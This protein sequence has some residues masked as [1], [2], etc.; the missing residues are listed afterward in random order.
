MDLESEEQH[1]PGLSVENKAESLKKSKIS[2]AR[3]FLLSI[4]QLEI[5]KKLPAG[6]DASILRWDTRSSGSNDK[7]GDSQSDWDSFTQDSGRRYGNQSRRPW[8]NPEHDGLLGSGA[9]PRPSGYAGAPL[10][11]KVRGDDNYVLNRSSEPYHPPRT[12]KALP[13]SRRD[14]TDSFNDETFGSTECSS[15]DRAEEERKRRASFELMR[16]EQQKALQEKLKQVDKRKELVTTDIDSLLE[17]PDHRQSVWSRAGEK[18][19]DHVT[20]VPQSDLGKHAMPAPAPAPRPLVPPGFATAALE[21]NVG[22]KLLVPTSASEVGNALLEDFTQANQTKGPLVGDGPGSDQENGKLS[23]VSDPSQ[24]QQNEI[25]TIGGPFAGGNDEDM[26]PASCFEFSNSSFGFENPTYRTSSVQ[27]ARESWVDGTITDFDAGRV[28]CSSAGVVDQDHAKTIL[29]K[30]FGNALA[31]NSVGSPSFVEIRFSYLIADLHTDVPVPDKWEADVQWQLIFGFKKCATTELFLQQ[32]QDELTALVASHAEKKIN[33]DTSSS[34]AKDLLSLI[35]SNEKG[36][37]MVSTMSN[38]RGIEHVQTISP[39]END[40]VPQKLVSSPTSS[41]MGIAEPPFCQVKPDVS[42]KVLTCEDLEQSILAEVNESS[43]H[44]QP[45]QGPWSISDAK[46]EQKMANVDDLASQHLLSLLHKGSN[47]KETPSAFSDTGSSGTLSVLG[48]TGMVDSASLENAE[49][50]ENSE[51]SL[52]LE[53]LF[54]KA[55]MKELHSVGAPVSAQRGPISGGAQ[56]D[57]SEPHMLPFSTTD[58]GRFHYTGSKEY[59]S[60]KPGHGRSSLA[61][62]HTQEAPSERIQEHWLGFD[63]RQ[64][65]GSN[66]GAVPGFDDRADVNLDIRLPEEESLINMGDPV[67]HDARKFMPAGSMARREELISSEA[68]VDIVDKLA[69][70]NVNV[71]DERPLGHLD[72][73]TVYHSAYNPVESEIQ[74]PHFHG[75]PSSPQFPPQVNHMRPS[76]HMLDHHAQRNPQIN[77][78]GPDSVHHDLP[79]GFPPNI[80]PHPF[81]GPAGPR[82][83]PAHHSLLQHAAPMPGN[84]PPTHSLQGLPRGAPPSHPMNH[85]PGYIPDLTPM[86]GFPLNHRQPNFGGIGLG[87][88]GTANTGGNHLDVERLIEMELRANAKQMPH[89]ASGHGPGIYGPE[90]DMAFRHR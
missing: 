51:K 37:P 48:L 74:Y 79:H 62:N 66:A 88:P 39:P 60:K 73:P 9:F 35:V 33:D 2:Y 41:A 36:R 57:V 67:N 47:V 4:S 1:D 14:P 69:A 89:A 70:L 81:H 87:I 64:T 5:C 19:E 46:V 16:K 30:L 49:T 10:T 22:A 44:V 68:P 6:F 21:K 52:T 58:D 61:L 27:E 71:K 20:P 45:M 32:T 82:F 75:R 59:T 25:G 34:T 78:I 85:M 11:S 3:D 63:D 38:E 8:Q 50:V 12:Y 42:S 84:F 65:K 7:D 23:L 24:K 40:E 43:A 53:A 13:H 31:L 77:F 76:F 17:N 26:M 28:T 56:A 90:I 80:F 18:S 72:S 83:D 55:F 15:Q 86:Q 54:G 29:D